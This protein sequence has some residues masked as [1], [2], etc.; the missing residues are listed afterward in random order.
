M[1]K[2]GVCGGGGGR[3]AVERTGKPRQ[4]YRQQAKC[5]KPPSDL[6]Q[7]QQSELSD[8]SSWL[9]PSQFVSNTNRTFMS[10]QLQRVMS[11]QSNSV[12]S[13]CT[14]QNSSHIIYLPTYLSIHPS[15]HLSIYLSI[16][17]LSLSFYLSTPLLSHLPTYLPI[18]LNH[19][20]SQIHKT[21]PC[22]NIKQTK[23]H[24]Q[25]SNMNFWSLSLT[26]FLHTFHSV[27]DSKARAKTDTNCVHRCQIQEYL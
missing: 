25:T 24:T 4:K 17:S 10:C 27:A 11:G 20:S 23:K 2:G 12:I 7:A 9:L 22:T 18:Y 26:T 19:F 16:I 13:R 21:N 3:Y 14:F 8:G 5:L 15:I 1:P 6:L